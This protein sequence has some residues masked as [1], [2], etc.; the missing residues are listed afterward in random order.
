MNHLNKKLIVI[1]EQDN[2][3]FNLKQQGFND[4]NEILGFLIRVTSVIHSE[5]ADKKGDRG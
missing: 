4:K 1:E 5:L 2:G 3:K